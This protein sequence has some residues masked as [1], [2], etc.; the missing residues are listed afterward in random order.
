MFPI[1]TLC[2]KGLDESRQYTMA[3]DM[4]PADDSRYKFVKGEWLATGKALDC[5]NSKSRMCYVHPESPLPGKMWMKQPVKFKRI[6]L[7]NNVKTAAE[8]RN[9]VSFQFYHYFILFVSPLHMTS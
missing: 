4:I 6:K 5:D 7:T 8:S 3:L 9:H 1:I 2:V